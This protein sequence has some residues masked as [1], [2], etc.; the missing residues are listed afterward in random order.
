[1]SNGHN[2]KYV[3][4]IR[5]QIANDADQ[6]DEPQEGVAITDHPVCP[7]CKKGKLVPA[8]CVHRF[9]IV[10]LNLNAY[11]QYLRKEIPDTS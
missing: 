6:T 1:M 8:F 3:A 5:K 4:L 9:G 11:F 2:K 10:I 7:Q